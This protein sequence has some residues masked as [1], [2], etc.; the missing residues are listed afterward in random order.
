LR[1]LDTDTCIAI[2]RGNAA[3]IERRA[4]TDDN[5][6]TTWIAVTE[7]HYGAAKSRAPEKNHGL[8]HRRHR[9]CQ[10]SDC[11]HREQAP[12]RAHPRRHARGLD[13]K[14]TLAARQTTEIGPTASP[15]ISG[16]DS[17]RGSRLSSTLV[18][19]QDSL[20]P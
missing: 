9:G 6:A 20:T 14:L 18:T 4:A 10:P 3:V 13:P 8:A 17:G 7:L 19:R 2:L 1:L 5:V 12:L 16:R 15:W 11:R